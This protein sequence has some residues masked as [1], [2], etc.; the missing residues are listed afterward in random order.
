[1]YGI[2]V[3]ETPVGFKWIGQLMRENEVI[4][5]GEE[6]GGLSIWGHIP[7][8]DGIIADLS[9]LEAV[10]YE[11]KPLYQIVEDLKDEID[12]HYINQRIDLRLSEETKNSA[13]KM[14]KESPP[15]SVAG[16]KV[17]DINKLDG[18]K[19]YFEDGSWMLI[20]PSGTE[21]LFRIYFETDSQDKL[22]RM[23]QDIK[24]IIEKI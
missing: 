19:F 15:S 11:N 6:S 4:I 5:G 17:S 13:M 3:K 8:K 21:P 14:F 23:S 16:I 12:S 24:K 1:M 7:E 10:A 22:D 2:E 9:I 20:R 18:I